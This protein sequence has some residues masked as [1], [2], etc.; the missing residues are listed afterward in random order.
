MPDRLAADWEGKMRSTVVLMALL[1]GACAG[2][3]ASEWQKQN[4]TMAQIEQDLNE[5]K[6]EADK[7]T[8]QSRG[9]PLAT[10]IN[11][12]LRVVSLR[13]QCMTVRGYQKR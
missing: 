5:C 4:S 10:G 2:S 8:P 6:Y 3:R 1:L 9:D 12:G 11:D 7:S 13:D